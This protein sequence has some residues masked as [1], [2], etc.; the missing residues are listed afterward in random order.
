MIKSIIICLIFFFGYLAVLPV[1]CSAEVLNSAGNIAWKVNTSIFDGPKVAII[2]C[3]NQNGPAGSLAA[4]QI[5]FWK[6]LSGSI[7]IADTCGIAFSYGN[8]YSDSLKEVIAKFA[9]D[10]IVE[11]WESYDYKAMIPDASGSTISFSGADITKGLMDS[12]LASVKNITI[13]NKQGYWQTF[14]RNNS[15]LGSIVSQYDKNKE[16]NLIKVITTA[17]EKNDYLYQ[18][19]RQ[20][21]SAVHAILN[22]IAVINKSISFDQVT[23]ISDDQNGTICNIAIY[24]G[25]GAVSSS[26]HSPYWIMCSIAH[27]PDTHTVLVGP[28]EIQNGILD[29]FDSVLFGGGGAKTQANGLAEN[30]RSQVKSFVRNGGRYFGICA[31]AFLA[32]SNSYGLNL[33]NAY[34]DGSKGTG[35]VELDFTDFG[36]ELLDISSSSPCKYS[37]GPQN[38]RP[39][40]AKGMRAY[41]VLA[42]YKATPG[43]LSRLKGTVAAIGGRYGKGYV[44][45]F[46]THPERY[47]GPQH[48][49]WHC[50]RPEK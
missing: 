24:N 47:P 7:L 33:L 22:K 14:Q 17:K 46:S 11:L 36:K 34:M 4:H 21:R 27:L 50:L 13:D 37:N 2:A 39:A 23:D 1:A 38:I 19:V 12:V 5:Q 25:P 35:I 16:V 43:S 30:G 49:L 31:G 3:S 10:W 18:R 20:H 26:G 40:G 6:P 42:T 28:E 9:P 44:I 41:D 48:A 45:A 15:S 32:S 8:N 29:Q